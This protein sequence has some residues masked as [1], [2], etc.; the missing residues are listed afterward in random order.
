MDD[1]DLEIE[2]IEN[3]ID[4]QRQKVDLLRQKSIEAEARAS[5]ETADDFDVENSNNPLQRN[6]EMSVRPSAASTSHGKNNITEKLLTP[7]KTDKDRAHSIVSSKSAKEPLK[8]E[9]KKE[10]FVDA[11]TRLSRL[12]TDLANER[13]LLAWIRTALA[14]AR[15]TV[16]FLALS[17]SSPFGDVSTKICYIGFAVLAL[18]MM[19]QGAERYKKIKTILQMPN[20][21]LYFDRLTTIPLNLTLIAV[22]A[23]VVLATA[24]DQWTN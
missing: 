6:T 15:T 14:S 17:G 21:P 22:L 2:A 11:L 4:L 24:A 18:L 7:D 1:I 3:L 20:P 16:S 12:T 13:T 8:I 5:E 10:Q 19:A 9:K 23:L